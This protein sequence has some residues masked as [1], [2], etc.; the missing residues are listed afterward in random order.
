MT[1][2]SSNCEF[3]PDEDKRLVEQYQNNFFVQIHA[4][5]IEY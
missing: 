1:R 3:A 5:Q 4:V 2:K